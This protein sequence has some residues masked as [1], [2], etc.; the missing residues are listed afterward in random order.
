[1]L[2]H[3]PSPAIWLEVTQLQLGPSI[4]AGLR[5][6]EPPMRSLKRSII[7]AFAFVFSLASLSAA[8]SPPATV[9]EADAK[10]PARPFPHFW[11]EMFGSGRAILTLRESYRR[12]L[13]EVRQITDFR[14]VRF[15]DILDDDIGVYDEDKEGPS[16]TSLMS[17]RSTTACSPTE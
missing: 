4:I 11:E 13:R 9:I 12:D 10:A 8:Q 1:M 6:I 7:L 3:Q 2:A 16:T 5:F 14:Y 17:I 15:H